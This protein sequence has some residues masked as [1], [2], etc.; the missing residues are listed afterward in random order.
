MLGEIPPL[1]S[2]RVPSKVGAAPTGDITLSF[3]STPGLGAH[4]SS[5]LYGGIL[6]S[7][8]I[9]DR[10]VVVLRTQDP[11]AGTVMTTIDTRYG[12]VDQPHTTA[13]T[14]SGQDK[15]Y[16][17]YNNLNGNPTGRTATLDISQD[18]KTSTPM[19]VQIL[20]ETRDNTFSENGNAQVP[21]ASSDGTVY[22]AFFH[23]SP[24]RLVVVR[25]DHWGADGF[26]DLK[27]PSDNAAGRYVT[28]IGQNPPSADSSLSIAVDPNNSSHVYVAWSGYVG[29]SSETIHVRRSI[30]RGENWSDDLMTVTNAINPE[31]AINN[32]GVVGVLYQQL[33]YGRWKT[34]ISLSTNMDATHFSVPGKLLA[35]TDAT[36]PVETFRPYL[37]DYASLVANGN[38]FVGMFSASNFPDKTNF[39]RGVRYQRE[40]DWDTHKLYVDVAHTQE[41]PPSIDPFFF[42]VETS[43]CNRIPHACGNFCRIRPELCSGIYDAW[44]WLRCPKCRVQILVDPGEIY[45]Q[46]AVYNT[47]GSKVGVLKPL[48]RPVLING[49]KYSYSIKVK[50]E[51]GVGYVLRANKPLGQNSQHAFTP[52]YT[53]NFE[54]TSR[55]Q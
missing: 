41:V 16:V 48:V 27:D 21:A 18:A 47:L 31:I 42:E 33:N 25:D 28:S 43:I 39:M 40:V 49:T 35:N 1:Y 38:N 13:K 45:K 46:V 9:S 36:T 55:M 51:K 37:G 22:A 3:G 24:M 54:K 44:W 50:L 15:L 34:Y 6:G 23:G 2:G 32:Q 8:T 20:I 29:V 7:N 30:D 52:R 10:P 14:G 17:G 19:F 12:W 5:W 26:A 53:V 4:P 11:Y